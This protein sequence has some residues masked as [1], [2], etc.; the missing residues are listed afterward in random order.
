[1]QIP[2]IK[3]KYLAVLKGLSEEPVKEVS[4]IGDR[5]KDLL[6]LLK[7]KENER[8]KLRLFDKSG[9][10]RPDVIIF[11]NGRDAN[12]IGGENSKINDGDEIVILPSVH[13]G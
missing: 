13:G 10:V 8:L 2:T 12:L 3:V 7:L 1:M 5:L 6:E 11:I 9:N 4:I